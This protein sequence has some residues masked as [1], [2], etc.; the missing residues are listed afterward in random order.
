MLLTFVQAAL[1]P[2]PGFAAAMALEKIGNIT[3][4][5]HILVNGARGWLWYVLDAAA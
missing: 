1:I 2:A 4:D 3:T 5:L